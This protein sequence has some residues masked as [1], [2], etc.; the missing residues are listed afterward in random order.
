MPSRTEPAEGSC[1]LQSFLASRARTKSAN[2]R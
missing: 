1:D 2:G